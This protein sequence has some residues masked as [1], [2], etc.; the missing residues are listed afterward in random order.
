MRFSWRPANKDNKLS[1]AQRTRARAKSSREIDTSRVEAPPPEF[2]WLARKPIGLRAN[3]RLATKIVRVAMTRRA[4]RAV[5]TQPLD[6][7]TDGLCSGQLL[8]WQP[9]TPSI[10]GLIRVSGSRSVLAELSGR[11][12]DWSHGKQ[13]NSLGLYCF[14]R[15]KGAWRAIAGGVATVL[16]PRAAVFFSL[17]L[18]DAGEG[19]ARSPGRRLWFCGD[20]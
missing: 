13:A 4:A 11:A 7:Q 8:T 19:R 12:S 3:W 17:Y 20:S 5:R 2:G 10:Y 1:S 6:G 15:T 18:E 16:R 14:A 9:P